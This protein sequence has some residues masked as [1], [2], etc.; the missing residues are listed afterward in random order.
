[1][2]PI[3]QWSGSQS[4]IQCQKDIAKN[5]VRDES[6]SLW[7]VT[8]WHHQQ[9][10]PFLPLPGPCTIWNTTCARGAHGSGTALWQ[11]RVEGIREH[12]RENSN[13][14]QQSHLSSVR[15]PQ[16][17]KVM[18]ASTQLLHSTGTK[19]L[20]PAPMRACNHLSSPLNGMPLVIPGGLAILC[21]Q[22]T[23]SHHGRC[24]HPHPAALAHSPVVAGTPILAHMLTSLSMLVLMSCQLVYKESL[25]TACTH[26]L[27]H[28]LTLLNLGCTY[29][30]DPMGLALLRA[31]HVLPQ[32][33]WPGRGS[34][35]CSHRRRSAGQANQKMDMTE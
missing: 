30:P 2:Q 11:V 34:A 25:A 8:T 20:H 28:L 23:C 1:M 19:Y 5:G 12:L 7:Y 24:S 35:R 27:S 6:N 29:R 26:I 32:R 9:G 17:C 18:Q 14:P 10:T 21:S 13:A 4:Q 31:G 3:P 15:G 16:N 22:Q 33:A